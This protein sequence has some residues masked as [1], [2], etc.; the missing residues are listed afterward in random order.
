MTD[1]RNPLLTPPPEGNSPARGATPA[2]SGDQ[3]GLPGRHAAA[4]YTPAGTPVPGGAPEQSPSEPNRAPRVPGSN[5]GSNGANGTGSNN[6]LPAR[7]TPGE[8]RPQSAELPARQPTSASHTLRPTGRHRRALPASLPQGAPALV[9]AIPGSDTDHSSSLANEI[10][11]II[12][13]DNPTVDVR[14]AWVDGGRADP[15]SLRA[16]LDDTAARRPAGAPCAVVVPLIAAPHPPVMKKIRE[17]IS[18]SGANVAIGEFVNSNPIMAEALHIRLAEAGLARADRVRLF[19]IV[20]AADGIIVVTTGGIEAVQSASITSVL[21]AARL[22]LPVLTASLD[23]DGAPSVEDAVMRLKEMGTTRIAISP[24]IIGPEL[25]TG[26]ETLGI[27][28]ECAKPIGA[29]GNIAKLVAAAY[30]Q[31]ISQMEIPG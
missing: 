11:T 12:A 7:R 13:I 24:C 23:G 26:L 14:T 16:A 31:A 4:G 3:S 5:G 22:A 28:A 30:G 2:Q 15:S 20:T 27:G 10:A 21:L 9:L 17:A 18:A 19:S 8:T 1:A 25:S 6:G 29:H